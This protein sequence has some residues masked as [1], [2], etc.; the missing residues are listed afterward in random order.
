VQGLVDAKES[1]DRN[2]TQS[3][4]EGTGQCRERKFLFKFTIAVL[5]HI[6]K[7]FMATLSQIAI[8]SVNIDNFAISKYWKP[9]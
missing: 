2:S 3:L 1:E 8:L 4:M 7:A 6:F 9:Y 5:W